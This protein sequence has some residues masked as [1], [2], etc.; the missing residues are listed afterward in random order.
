MRNALGLAYDD[1]A[2]SI[3]LA[4]SQDKTQADGEPDDQTVF[5]RLGLRTLGEA[6]TST[7]ADY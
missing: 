6:N 2:F 1:E 4:Y 5:L 3:S 7:A